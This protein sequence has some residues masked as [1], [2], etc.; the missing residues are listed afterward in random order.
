MSFFSFKTLAVGLAGLVLACPAYAASGGGAQ[1]FDWQ[2]VWGRMPDE[3]IPAGQHSIKRNIRTWVELC[4]NPQAQPGEIK[5]YSINVT[6]GRAPDYVIDTTEYFRQGVNEK[7]CPMRACE[8]VNG[9]GSRACLLAIYANIEPN[10]FAGKPGDGPC[11]ATARQNTE[12][13]ADCY[14][15]PSQCPALFDYDMGPPLLLRHAFEWNFMPVGAFQVKIATFINMYGGKMYRT[16]NANPVLSIDTNK[17]ACTKEELEANAN[18]C[19]KYY[20]YM[21]GQFNDLYDAQPNPGKV[22]NDERITFAPYDR[23][24]ALIGRAW[25]R[26]VNLDPDYQM[27]G[28]VGTKKGFMA[29]QYAPTYS[30]GMSCR[31][32]SNTAP[33]SQI[34]PAHLLGEVMAYVDSVQN[35]RVY[36]VSI[37]N[38]DKKFT[39]W[40]GQTNC[41]PLACGEAAVVGAERRCQRASSAYG[42]CSECASVIDDDPMM[43]APHQCTFTLR[44]YGPP[45]PQ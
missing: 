38:C 26:T 1:E 33:T 20:Q 19:I 45:C 25:G 31:Q 32:F 28:M 18:R 13:R 4:G 41:P 43:L 14:A 35:G 8:D 27:R 11:P 16:F 29:L 17:S 10:Q 30:G 42:E 37:A 6:G 36:G 23:K 39:P 9:D 2:S 21:N 5:S 24:K 44:C 7:T 34:A 3:K 15:L 12:C 40:V 22:E